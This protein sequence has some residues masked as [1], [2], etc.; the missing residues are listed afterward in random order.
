MTESYAATLSIVEVPRLS[1]DALR[2][3]YD[4]IAAHRLSS[5]TSSGTTRTGG[6]D[7]GTARAMAATRSPD[8]RQRA[9]QLQPLEALSRSEITNLLRLLLNECVAGA[10]SVK[11]PD[12][13]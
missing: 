12:N 13:E 7:D 9:T 11:E 3:L 5:S 4:L 6:G 1:L 2:T 10:A 8:A